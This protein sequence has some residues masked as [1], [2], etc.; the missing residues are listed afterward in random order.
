MEPL[1]WME[2]ARAETEAQAVKLAA[3]L[4]RNDSVARVVAAHEVAAII[5][6]DQSIL[7]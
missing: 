2:I 5:A 1:S 6:N 4:R 3:T 7:D